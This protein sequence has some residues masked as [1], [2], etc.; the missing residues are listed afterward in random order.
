MNEVDFSFSVHG[1]VAILTAH[2]DPAS[3]WLNENIGE[4]RMEFAGGTVCEPRYLEDILRG[5]VVE[6]F[7][8]REE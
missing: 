8:V 6:G 1:S 5:I 4:E 2:T 3:L 7:I